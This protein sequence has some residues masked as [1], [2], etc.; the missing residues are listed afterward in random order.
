MNR[1]RWFLTFLVLGSIL[2]TGAS[3]A[4]FKTE[5]EQVAE[6]IKSPGVT[7][8]HFWAPWNLNCNAEL[9]KNG[10]STF[11]DTNMETKFI[12]I[13]SWHN[14]DGRA[15]LEKNDI[16][17]QANFQLL[18]HPNPSKKEGE[19]FDKFLGLPVTWLPTT[20]VF[21]DGKLRYAL[22][23]GEVRFPLLQ[24]LIRDADEKWAK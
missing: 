14:D 5:E 1:F 8:V 6:A 3:A 10:W 7:V 2:A 11:I 4:T 22:S 16:G 17:K 9:A 20:W 23:Y 24:Q 13:T 21:R 15:L 12:F 19:R 18:L